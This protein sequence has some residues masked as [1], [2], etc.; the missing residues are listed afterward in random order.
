MKPGLDISEV[1]AAE[2]AAIRHLEHEIPREM[3]RIASDAA[4]EEQRGHTYQNRTGDLERST[5]ATAPE[6]SSDE[7]RVDLVAEMPYASY[8]NT[9]G[10]MVID[11]AADH[12][13]TEMEFFFDGM[14]F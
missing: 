1:I 3:H 4:T 2:R 8:V 14:T 6:T 12:A 7:T 9:R 11:E 10:Y 5:K 13:A